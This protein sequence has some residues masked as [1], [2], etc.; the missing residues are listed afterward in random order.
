MYKQYFKLKAYFLTM[1]STRYNIGIESTELLMLRLCSLHKRGTINYTALK[2]YIKHYKAGT[3]MRDINTYKIPIKIE[4]YSGAGAYAWYN[5]DN[6]VNTTFD[7]WEDFVVENP[8]L[9]VDLT[10]EDLRYYFKLFYSKKD[11]NI[12]K[13]IW[14][15]VFKGFIEI[16]ANSSS[17]WYTS[18]GTRYSELVHP[19]IIKKIRYMSI[20]D[21]RERYCNERNCD[22][23]C[24]CEREVYNN[25]YNG[26]SELYFK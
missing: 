7:C 25:I 11:K 23:N 16:F 4:R 15:V 13:D 1:D 2:E 12:D 21:Y 22:W 18:D 10:Y 5:K 6:S 19:E 20:N 3:L 14:D 17:G 9:T 8:Y 24:R 26:I